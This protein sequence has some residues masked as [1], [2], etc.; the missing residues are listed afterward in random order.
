VIFDFGGS[1]SKNRAIQ[2][3]KKSK[4][5]IASRNTNFGFPPL[6]GFIPINARRSRL[7]IWSDRS[8]LAI[9]CG[10]CFPKVAKRIIAAISIYVIDLARRPLAIS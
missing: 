5:D 4:P 10:G 1:P 9:L 8:V 2:I 3:T 6:M 7:I